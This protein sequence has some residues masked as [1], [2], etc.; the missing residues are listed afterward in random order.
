MGARPNIATLGGHDRL[1]AR[2]GAVLVVELLVVAMIGAG[3]TQRSEECRE[4]SVPRVMSQSLG[5]VGPSSAD[6]ATIPTPPSPGLHLV[7][8]RTGEVTRLPV[9]AR[10]GWPD[11]STDG[12]RIAWA[13]GFVSNVDGSNV[14]RV[15]A[16]IRPD[17]SP[18]G[19]RIAFD[20][21]TFRVDGSIFVINLRSGDTCRVR[22]V[23][24]APYAADWS[25]DGTK[26]LYLSPWGAKDREIRVV[27][28]ATGVDTR[29]RRVD[30]HD[31]PWD[32]ATWSPDGRRI[33]FECDTG[34]CV[35]GAD[36][37]N[38][39]KL[40]CCPIRDH[41]TQAPQWSPDG[42][43]IVYWSDQTWTDQEDVGDV[44]MLDLTTGVER[45]IMASAA[46][47]VWAGPDM[48]IVRVVCHYEQDGSGECT[49]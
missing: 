38:V 18:D 9:G 3:C 10:L 26:I 5:R 48:L 27:D 49:Y 43:M 14:H 20:S 47:P 44:Y 2:P 37:S 36:G 25:P 4:G 16:G 33:V 34:I 17:W 8:I 35:M 42:T 46:E 24:D 15:G 39:Q 40:T 45:L 30:G 31:S 6:R 11:V 12:R 7:N 29:L 28:L 23:G 19:I 22:T 41:G 21:S 1:H 32:S 13:E